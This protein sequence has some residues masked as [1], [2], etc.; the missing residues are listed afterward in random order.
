MRV[1][2]IRPGRICAAGT[3]LFLFSTLLSLPANG[4]EAVVEGWKDTAEFSYVATSGN[5][6]T[7]TLGF[8]NKLWRAW[9]KS[10]FELNAGGIRSESTIV[11]DRLAIGSPGNFDYDET[12]ETDTTAENYFLNGRYDRK[13]TDRFFWFAGAG[14]D[15]NEFAGI[16]DRYTGFGGVGNIWVDQERIKFKTDYAVTYTEQDDVV[17]NPDF[18][19]SFLGLRFSWGYL[20]QFGEVTTYG[21]DLVLNANIDET[22]DWRGNMVNWVAVVLSSRL[23]LKLS[24]EVIYDHMPAQQ[25]VPLFTTAGGAQNG[26]VLVDLD[27]F[28]TVFTAS[29]VVNFK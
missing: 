22:D 6:E 12:E 17:P 19:D 2:A 18:D 15:R 11:I 28:D 7:R 4:A 16:R 24:H 13:I 3:A 1:I 26:T 5:S 20:H 23:G 10:A 9:T 21:N 8:K 27:E 29:L 25:E 14:W